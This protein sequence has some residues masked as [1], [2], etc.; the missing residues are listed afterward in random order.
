MA[1]AKSKERVTDMKL[2]EMQVAF[3]EL[4]KKGYTSRGT[5]NVRE[6]H[7]VVEELIDVRKRN[8]SKV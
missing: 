1:K 3:Q 7:L 4:Q 6:L 8:Q 5:F 2:A